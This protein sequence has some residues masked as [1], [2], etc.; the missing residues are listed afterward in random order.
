MLDPTL[1]NT[2][3]E[4]LSGALSSDQI[5]EIGRFL[6]K[7]HS[8]HSTLGINQHFTVAPRKAAS[9]LVEEC[10]DNSCEESLFKFL[11]ELDGEKLLGKRVE[12]EDLE[13]LMNA[14]A[15]SGYLYDQKRRK[16]RKIR[17]NLEDMPNWGALKEGK[18]YEVSV[19][20]VDIVG[21]SELVK[22]HGRKK[23]EKLYYE[24]WNLLR[25]VLFVYDGR[26]WDWSGDGGLVAFT[27]KRH[28]ER[29]V[30]FALELQ[31]MIKVFN[32]NP[33]K[34]VPDDIAVRI[35]LDAGKIKYSDNIG[36][37]VS[38]VINY[39][40]HLE[41]SFTA[42]GGISISRDLLDA[43]P[44]KMLRH[45]DEKGQFEGRNALVCSWTG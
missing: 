42:P 32:V 44:R 26:I 3:V 38:D 11:V 29:A 23:A 22:R 35:G 40:A 25:R 31:Q 4:M 2:I 13:N 41:K 39:A 1:R 16:V 37:I 21:S 45:F 33:H 36:Q 5:D 15:R 28:Q 9:A 43:V 34:T 30:L 24:F 27:F 12:F 14:M 18:Q 7:H 8:S 19:G 6:M 20:S 10:I 17:E